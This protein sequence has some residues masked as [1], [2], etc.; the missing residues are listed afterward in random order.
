VKNNG[1]LH[2]GRPINDQILAAGALWLNLIARLFVG[3]EVLEVH[4]AVA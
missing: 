1:P 2:A 3:F 4:P